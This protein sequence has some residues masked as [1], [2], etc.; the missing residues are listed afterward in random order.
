MFE[1]IIFNWI[2]LHLLYLR[3]KPKLE[4]LRGHNAIPLMSIK[5]DFRLVY[6]DFTICHKIEVQ[7]IDV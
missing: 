6:Y 2:N 4:K 5:I 3:V 1:F 7:Q